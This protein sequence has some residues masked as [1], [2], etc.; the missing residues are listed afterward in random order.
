MLLFYLRK[1]KKDPKRF[2]MKVKLSPK[3][4]QERRR[5]LFECFDILVSGKQKNESR[6]SKGKEYKNSAKM[7]HYLIIDT[8]PWSV[9]IKVDK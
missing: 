8:L 9:K 5:L 6:E 1:N 4:E 7:L 2:K 3:L